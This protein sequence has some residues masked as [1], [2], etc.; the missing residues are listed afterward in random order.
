MIDET[1]LS[2]YGMEAATSPT[3]KF[4]IL[5]NRGDRFRAWVGNTSTYNARTKL[6]RKTRLKKGEETPT[7]RK[8]SRQSTN[9][10]VNTPSAMMLSQPYAL[11]PMARLPQ[12]PAGECAFREDGCRSGAH[13]VHASAWQS[14]YA[15]SPPFPSDAISPC[16]FQQGR[17]SDAN[18]IDGPSTYR[19]YRAHDDADA[20]AAAP[21][22]AQSASQS[23][24]SSEDD[25]DE[26]SAGYREQAGD[27]TSASAPYAE[28]YTSA[29]RGE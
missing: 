24:H 7:R 27:P 8:V 17:S 15:D 13:G 3:G 14:R 26:C 1:D 5:N 28:E 10:L 20:A 6:V 21:D 25:T 23:G 12:G 19:A 9:V 2:R 16:E 18:G 4:T 11:I 22:V 29:G